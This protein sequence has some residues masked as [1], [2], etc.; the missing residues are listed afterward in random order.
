MITKM[1][2]LSFLVFHQEY[3]SFLSSI[4]ELGV[5]HIQPRQA[6]LMTPELEDNLNKKA[7]YKDILKEM[8]FAVAEG[9]DEN[10][11]D[12]LSA[13]EIIAK[14]R[15][16][17]TE[18]Q[19]IQQGL[20][21]IEKDIQDMKPWG[22]FSWDTI[23]QLRGAG[24][25][26]KFFSC[27]ERE[28]QKDW[29]NTCDIVEIERGMGRVNFLAISKDPIYLG[30]EPVQLP[31]SSLSQLE[32]KLADTQAQLQGIKDSKAAFCNKYYNTLAGID[33][34]LE[35][36]IDLIKVRLQGEA[37]ADG[38]V[39]VMDGWI[40]ADQEKDVTSQLDQ[41]SAYYEVRD[42]V[43]GDDVPIKLKNNS[44]VHAYEVLTKMYGLPVYSEFDPTPLIAPFFSLFFA[45]CLGDAGYGLM[46]VL[47]GLFLKGKM[48]EDMK[49]MMNLVIFLGL[50]TTVFGMI[51][52]T[53]FG[54]NLFESNI[55]DS[56][57]KF[58][59]SGKFGDTAYDA[60]M[61]LALGIG[62]V[63]TLVAMFMKAFKQTVLFGF[64]NALKE[65]GWL[66]VVG[67]FTVV[68]T[69]TAASVIS[70]SV[71]TWAFIVI[72]G[73]GAIGIYLLN[74]L[75]RNV[76]LNIGSGLWDTYNMASGLL[77]DILSYV[78]LYALGLAGGMLGGIFNT[79]GLMSQEGVGG[80]PGWICCGLIMVGGHTLNIAMSCLSAFVHPLR[81]NFVEYFKNAGYEGTGGE[82]KPFAI[83][84][85]K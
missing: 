54:V 28:Y 19:E 62:V 74:D 79:L 48:S 33:Q 57:K 4:R 82:Y 73:I 5:I 30:I 16:F 1:K 65:W 63:H 2:K 12:D 64:K 53:C 18:A 72:G 37:A 35:D 41:M 55:P 59:I 40:P 34:A 27:T 9:G 58:M 17:G 78:R 6:G 26:V 14:Y 39:V 80:V 20:P 68:G 70:S 7:L 83:T 44:I 11:Y 13:D 50:V 61:V 38:A 85:K 24:Y 81:L 32:G 47:L 76:F 84:N 8:S 22:E 51:L 42:A 67:G 45:F 46:L 69:L 10:I 21:L 52:G 36:D 43:P 49:P 75:K 71:S 31:D 23:N 25:D 66:F 29:E 77:G 15:Q 60:Q 3:D 56:M